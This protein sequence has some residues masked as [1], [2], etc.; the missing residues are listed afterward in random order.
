[1]IEVAFERRHR[2]LLSRFIGVFSFDDIEALD[3]VVK[4]VVHENGPVAGLLDL[5]NVDTIAVPPWRLIQRGRAPQIALGQQRVMVAPD[6]PLHD[7]ARAYADQQRDYGNLEPIVVRS[8]EEAYDVLGIAD[9]V[10]EPV[11]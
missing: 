2:I 4:K 11:V 9:P 7:M 10:F 3:R 1:M 8:L 6:G 5:S